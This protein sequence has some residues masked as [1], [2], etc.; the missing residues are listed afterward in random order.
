VIVWAKTEHGKSIPVNPEPAENGNLILVSDRGVE[1]TGEVSRYGRPV[2]AL[3][4]PNGTHV[5]HWV[6]CPDANKW[7]HHIR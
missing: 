7:R 3:V 2:T 5:A 4:R 1:R 6:T